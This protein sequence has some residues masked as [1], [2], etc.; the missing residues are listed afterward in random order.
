MIIKDRLAR[1]KTYVEVLRALKSRVSGP[2]GLAEDYVVR[3]AVERYMHLAL[4][5]L[6]DV[7]MRLA[8]LTG[9]G[10]P[11]RYRDIAKILKELGALDGG[12]A[13]RLELWI[14]LRN[15]LVHGYADVDYG[16]L[17][18]ALDELDEL[19]RLIE[20]IGYFVE[21]EGI[22]P[23]Q[24]AFGEVEEV[25]KKHDLIFAYVFGSRARGGRGG[26]IDVAV[27]AGRPL[28][29]RELVKLAHELEDSLG[30]AVDVVDLYDAPPLLAYEVVSKGVVVL[31]RDRERRVEFEVKVLKEFL[32]LRPR[33]E[34]Y[35]R[36]LLS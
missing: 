1:A 25:L 4:E 36:E 21:R 35:Y 12:E 10:K 18:E 20:K 9:R 24:T 33:L 2:R 3:G 6:I 19:E 13:E 30:T 11:E 7:G 34:R 23:P 15:I 32:D 27:Y 5:A 14:G 26:D 22:D 31:D 17:S 8:A 29:W 28:K 16:K